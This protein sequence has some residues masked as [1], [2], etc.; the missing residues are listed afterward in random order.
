M[1]DAALL[2]REASHSGAPVL[3]KLAESGKPLLLRLP[4]D[5]GNRAW[6]EQA[7]RASW[8]LRW[9]KER[10]HWE[11]PRAW[12]EALAMHVI[13]RHGRLW[14]F[15]EVKD[16]HACDD[17]CMNA[18]GLECVCGCGGKNH[19]LGDPRGWGR[20]VVESGFTNWGDRLFACRFIEPRASAAFTGL[21]GPA[22]L[23][24]VQ[25]SA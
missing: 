16:P 25:P 2:W 19:G 8:R 12:F 11:T 6:I 18:R 5:P 20:S 1:T 3:V 13:R 22:T 15:Q 10:R 21:L 9:D 7:G 24:T 4:F 17:R 14:V 23:T